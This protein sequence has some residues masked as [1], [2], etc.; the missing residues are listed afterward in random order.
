MIQRRHRFLCLYCAVI[1]VVVVACGQKQ[2]PSLPASRSG[3]QKSADSIV[4][5]E[6]IYG[7]SRLDSNSYDLNVFE[8]GIVVN[9]SF[10]PAHYEILSS[11]D[12]VSALWIVTT[13]G[14]PI[15]VIPEGLFARVLILDVTR[16]PSRIDEL[17]RSCKGV[18][19]ELL[20]LRGGGIPR[21]IPDG[22]L[23]SIKYLYVQECSAVSVLALRRSF[24][25]LLHFAAF[26]SSVSLDDSTS[27]GWNLEDLTVRKCRG[28]ERSALYR[29]VSRM[30]TL[31]YFGVDITY[32][33]ELQ[34]IHV[35]K[36]RELQIC[37]NRKMGRVKRIPRLPSVAT[38][39]VSDDE[40]ASPSFERAMAKQAGKGTRVY[41]SFKLNY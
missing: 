23:S 26:K 1:A 22:T 30:D 33:T 18:T 21:E 41:Y 12:S 19:A 36:T 28:F 25:H 20:I 24:P 35:V 10:D 39:S 7:A 37:L 16:A 38:I 32:V 9:A 6:A 8:D 17:L 15:N 5:S 34:G 29:Y 31:D 14:M 3:A 2:E 11:R 13:E 40:K 27:S 4:R